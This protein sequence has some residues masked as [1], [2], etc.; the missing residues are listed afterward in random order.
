MKSLHYYKLLVFAL[1][2]PLMVEA[3]GPAPFGDIPASLSIGTGQ[4][5]R[6]NAGGTAFESYTPSVG[7]PGGSNT[8]LQY[9]NSNAFGGISS[10]T[11]DGVIPLTLAMPD[12]QVTETVGFRVQ[13][14]T[15]ATNTIQRQFSPAIE[16]IGQ[17][18]NGAVSKSVGFRLTNE[19]NN[20][21]TGRGVLW[22]QSSNDNLATW[23]DLFY[24]DT[25]GSTVTPQI[26]L[27]FTGTSDAP[28]IA[29]D[30][31]S[32]LGIYTD[33]GNIQATSNIGI[34]DE[35]I[36][37]WVSNDTGIARNDAGIVE[38]NNGTPGTQAKIIANNI[39]QKITFV[40]DA[41][42]VLTTGTKNPIK[43]GLP[44]T[45]ASWTMMCKPSGSVTV[46]V[47]RSA[48]GNGLPVTSI[49]G[50][51][52]KPAISSNVEANGLTTDWGSPSLAADDNLAI[53]LSGISTATYVELTL[54]Y[55]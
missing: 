2:F 45:L 43:I 3:S 6:R 26:V 52:T 10:L 27:S 18:W 25:T 23:P 39:Y 24:I 49:V 48:T 35:N 42:G 53:S 32:A 7:V 33:N 47:L 21:D 15:A 16:L 13:N 20:G 28:A 1:S 54:Y 31:N 40:V 55:Q 11:Y 17:V 41:G 30:S 14:N 29:F 22:L 12:L 37:T 46:D 38:I 8:Q 36:F 50:V 5:V 4:S 44:G 51:G 19:P 34:P 9:N